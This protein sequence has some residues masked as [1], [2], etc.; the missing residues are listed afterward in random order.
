[1]LSFKPTFSLSSFTF[2]KRLFSSSL[3]ATGLLNQRSYKLH[4]QEK[5]QQQKEKERKKPQKL[6]SQCITP[7]RIK[8][9]AHL[10]FYFYI[11]NHHFNLGI[12]PDTKDTLEQ[13]L[14]NSNVYNK[15]ITFFL[16]KSTENVT[17]ANNSL[18]VFLC[19]L[20]PIVVF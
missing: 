20:L 6:T 8:C 19:H 14:V 15:Q 17:H 5:K 3:S 18:K 4:V 16:C 12:T 7:T 1:M 2:I 13:E 10:H 9:M 11:N